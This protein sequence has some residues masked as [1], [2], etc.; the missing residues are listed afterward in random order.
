[1]SWLLKNR[2]KIY[3]YPC[4]PYERNEFP[5]A[6]NHYNCPIVTSYA[7][8]IKNNVDELND[9]SIDFPQSFYGL[10]FRRNSYCPAGGDFSKELPAS[11]VKN[12]AH[13]AWEELDAVRHDVQKKAKKPWLISKKPGGEALFLPDVR[14]TSTRKSTTVF[15]I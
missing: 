9:P 6:V 5:D 4:I 3:F 8:N 10:Y 12:A 15:R 14:T 7:E 2:G 13:K 11:E 1:M